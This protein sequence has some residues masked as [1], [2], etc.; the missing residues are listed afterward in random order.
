MPCP[1]PGN[2]PDPGIEPMSLTSPAYVGGFFTISATWGA[3]GIS[4]KENIYIY[5]Y[6]YILSYYSLLWSCWNLRQIIFFLCSDP[7]SDFPIHCKQNLKSF[8]AYIVLQPGSLGPPH[9]LLTLLSHLPPLFSLCS[10]H[11]ASSLF[12]DHTKHIHITR[13]IF[14][15]FPSAWNALSPEVAILTSFTPPAF[16]KLWP[17]QVLTDNSI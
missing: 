4:G 5:M 10:S 14:S 8:C 16:H 12:P 13:Q 11:P 17:Q 2:L 6:V 3:G 9:N 15:L 1:P 7:S